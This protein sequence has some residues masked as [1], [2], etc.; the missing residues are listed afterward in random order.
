MD[1][2]F[3]TQKYHFKSMEIKNIVLLVGDS[4]ELFALV[5]ENSFRIEDNLITEKIFDLIESIE[6]GFTRMVYQ[7][8]YDQHMDEPRILIFKDHDQSI[9][10]IS[11]MEFE[12]PM[13]FDNLMN[14]KDDVFDYLNKKNN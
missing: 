5:D 6:S 4:K 8:S 11:V 2:S 14:L 3:A 1:L 12:N 10:P 9:L 7:M 13:V